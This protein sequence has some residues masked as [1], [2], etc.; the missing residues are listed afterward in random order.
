MGK[1]IRESSIG[2]NFF[3]NRE[4]GLFLLVYV[5]DIKLVGKK[6][7]IDRMWK[8]HLKDVDLGEPT[9]FLDHFHLGCTQRD[10]GITILKVMR[11]NVWSDIA[12]WRTEQPDDHQFKE[13]ELGS[14][15]QLS[16]VCS[17]I[18]LKCLYVGR[19]GRPDIQRPVNKLARAVTK[20]TR[21]CDKGLARL[22]S[23][24]SSH[25]RI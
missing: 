6:H 1:A 7:N 9:S 5:D 21:A 22:I 3:V 4:K 20:W 24:Y 8:V 15:G 11:R 16:N 2:K 12:D 19:I 23:L 17:Q 14:V 13:E 25:K 18:G 10:H